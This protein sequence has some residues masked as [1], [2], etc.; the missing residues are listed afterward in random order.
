MSQSEIPRSEDRSERPAGDP[1]PHEGRIRSRNALRPPKA[2]TRSG[3]WLLVALLALSAPALAADVGPF[4][5]GAPW[6]LAPT[7]G[8]T[9]P[10]PVGADGVPER[11][12]APGADR[13]AG[14]LAPAGLR[15]FVDPVDG[16][17]LPH[18]RPE[19][20]HLLQQAVEESFQLRPHRGEP[21]TFVLSNGGTGAW[22]GDRFMTSTVAHVG[23][24]GTLHT[25][26][27]HGP[28]EHPG[29]VPGNGERAEGPQPSA[30]TT[31]APVK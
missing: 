14:S 27:Q 19:Q 8:L 12:R 9:S 20:R 13:T 7:Q 2:R 16:H 10:G 26:C 5:L 22:V 11:L 15:V 1:S 3:L 17:V 23:P 28:G 29:Q 25:R 30:P 18:P 31:S 4:A 21:Y 6:V 24:D